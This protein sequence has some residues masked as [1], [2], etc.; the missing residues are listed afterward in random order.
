[1]SDSNDR[2]RG[3]LTPADRELL[4]GDVEY[5]HKQQYTDRRRQIRE[6]IANGLLDFSFIQYL[7]QDRD[8]K[9]IFQD[10]TGEAGVEKAE[11]HQSIRA[12]L[13]WVYFGLKEQNYD[14]KRLLSE[15]IEQAE[16]D[17]TKRYQGESANVDVRFEV[18]KTQ[19]YNVDSLVG[20]IEKGGPVQAN[21]LYKLL[22]LSGGVPIDTSELDSIRV[23]FDSSYPEGEKAVLES[24]F[25]EYLGVEVEVQDAI[26]RVDLP[27]NGFENESAVIDPDHPGSD[28]S[29]IKYYRSLPDIDFD[30]VEADAGSIDEIKSDGDEEGREKETH[31]FIGGGEDLQP[32]IHQVAK[33]DEATLQE[34]TNP[35]LILKLLKVVQD[36]F[37]STME[38][39]AA[40]GAPPAATQQHLSELLDEG[41]LNKR[42]TI[43]DRGEQHFIWWL[44]DRESAIESE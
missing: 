24:L 42:S 8:R 40:L 16:K 18:D 33:E 9:R 30:A 5:R 12:M 35:K 2:P 32:T 10:P 4:R 21:R 14:F 6:R 31:S 37:V 22:E 11:F 29:E 20:S 41:Y 38:V 28:P 3:I 26:A 43:D 13:Y 17:Y 25:S 36:Q 23:W 39:S 15:A 27:E 44:R 34:Y 19:E 1:M 7:L